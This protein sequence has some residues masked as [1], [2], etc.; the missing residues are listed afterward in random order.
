MILG[1]AWQLF[2]QFISAFVYGMVLMMQSKLGEF[3]KMSI[4][5]IETIETLKW[6]WSRAFKQLFREQTAKMI[7]GGFVMFW[8]IQKLELLKLFHFLVNG[9]CV[10]L[11][12]FLSSNFLPQQINESYLSSGLIAGGLLTII[13]DV[14]LKGIHGPSIE[15]TIT[16]NHGIKLSIKNSVILGTLFGLIA[17]LVW[18]FTAL[19]MGIK[20][21]YIIGLLAFPFV[22][23]SFGIYTSFPI[24]QHL[25]LRMILKT[26]GYIPY[27]YSKFLDYAAERIFLQKVGG[28]YMFIH[29][30]LQEHFDS[31]ELKQK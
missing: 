17:I 1:I 3:K 18:G 4:D 6:S 23:V 20:Q 14:F 19:I 2:G 13:L 11:N 7:V 26:T 30:V 27:H 22:G 10:L 29:R 25:I 15:K 8:L 28:G 5:R 12:N 16:P 24:I 31:M 9:F 21:W